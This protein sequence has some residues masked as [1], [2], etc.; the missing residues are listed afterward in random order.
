M[1]PALPRLHGSELPWLQ[2][3][4]CSLILHPWQR[5][6]RD[7]GY[8][9]VSRLVF[10]G[11]MLRS[12]KMPPM[13]KVRIL[14]SDPDAT[15]SSGDED[16]Q[17]P[18]KQKKV[19]R[20]VL[21]PVKQ[22][23]TSKPLKNTMP[24]GTKDLNGLEKKVSSSRYRGVRL[25]D[26]G[27]W[28]AEIRNPLTKK[29]EYSLH[30]TE[31]AAA[32]AY[33]AKWNQFHAEMQSMKAQPPLR[34]HAGLSSSSLVSCISSSVLCEKKAQEAQNRVGSLMK[35]NCEPMDESLLNLS[36]K[37]MEI[38]D[39]SMVNRKDV[40]P[41]RDSVS[42]TDELPPDDF[43]RPEDMFTV[44]DFI[45]TPYIPLDNDYIG[46]ADISHLPLP[47]K[48]PEFDLDAELDWSGFDFISLEHEL[49]LL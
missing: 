1:S 32:A 15:D 44:S 3:S 40:H 49:D 29:R 17:N 9:R 2:A 20:E 38:S 43:T 45:G 36:P 22:Y 33:Q 10:L 34:K 11:K 12:T 18:E 5:G 25:R 46:L 48:D 37:P 16:G 4:S 13:R 42:P 41:V 39:N 24:C 28:Q 21:I 7:C 8:F 14:F 31:E 47:I 27:R 26:S 30:D 6:A 23:K 19:I 35:I